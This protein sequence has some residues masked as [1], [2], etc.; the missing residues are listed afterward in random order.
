MVRFTKES[1][2][3]LREAV[4]I[5]DLISRHVPL[6][7]AGTT[8][9]GLCPFHD[10]KTP[11]F[12]VN[13]ASRHYHCFGCG[14]HGDAV[15]FLMQ[16]ERL[17]FKQALEFLSE[18]FGVPL[19][20]EK[21]DIDERGVPKARLRQVNE[22]A[23]NFF[24]TFLLHADEAEGARGYLAKRG[25]SLTFLQAFLIGYAPRLPGALR[26]YLHSSGFSEE[27][28]EHAGL[29]SRHEGR[30][31]EFFFERITFP[32][33]DAIG[34]TIGFSARKWREETF[35]G[36][37]INTQ[38]T[39]L[40]KKSKVLFGLFYSKKRMMRDR[41]ACIVEG[42]VDALRLIEAGFDFTVASLGTAFGLPH[43]EQLK[44]MGV[45][46]VYLSLD[47]DD[48]G[49]ISAEKAG[50][51]LMKK[52]IGVRVVQFS[53]AKDPDEL[54]EKKGKMVF[55]QALASAMDFL[56]FVISRAKA[57]CNWSSP[58]EKDK[59][60]RGIEEKI[61]EWENPILVYETLKQL[62]SMADVPESLLNIGTAPFA[63]M[64]GKHPLPTLQP[65]AKEPDLILELD[66]VRWLVFAGPESG[67]FVQCCVDH[68]AAEDFT[69]DIPRQLFCLAIERLQKGERPDFM[70][71]AGEV[72]IES[73]SAAFKTLFSRRQRIEKALP[74]ASESV[75]KI[76]ERNWLKKRESIRKAM[77]DPQV[78]EEEQM[79]LARAFDEL[80][81]NPPIVPSFV[82]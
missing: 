19:E 30:L 74:M 46:E 76:K 79:L 3:R 48:A 80:T 4:D 39:Q 69:H 6:K 32:I 9:K 40:F 43:V 16:H 33:L 28:M 13:K 18:R 57:T 25:F 67:Q 78:S 66:L 15:A 61:R 26:K 73:I 63:T 55:F 21:G 11:S 68:L 42:Q 24:H 34:H 8:F 2:Q 36:K 70:S 44:A 65:E 27:E 75:K 17:D 37:Y 47:G 31:R 64:I 59:A 38:E 41:I 35:G 14:A 72:D 50:H 49:L 62:S 54:L 1:V 81:K 60:V 45:E 53:D 10:E 52:G 77:E 22:A 71:F 58:R 51:L 20:S 29:L 7:R 82:P 23:S 56:P 5:V 12:T